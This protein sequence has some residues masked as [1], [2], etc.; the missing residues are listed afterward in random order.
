MVVHAG[1]APTATR[2]R[3]SSTAWRSSASDLVKLG[4]T[5]DISK[6][7]LKHRVGAMYISTAVIAGDYLYTYNDVGVPGCYE[8]KTGKEL[9][10]DQIEERPG[11]TTAWGSPV[12][13]A[14][15][16]YITD[17][18]GTTSVFAAGPKYELLATNRLQRT[19]QRLDRRRRTATSS[20][21]RTSTCGASARRSSAQ[22]QTSTVG[23]I[24][25]PSLSA[26]DG[27]TIHPTRSRHV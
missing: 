8:W 9:W 13:A 21:A 1:R 19:L 15:R 14:G 27:S 24:V 16:I 18:Q 17:Q 11:G 3:C 25:N 12:H 2:R 10:K 20:S 7:R 6:D 5:G 23:R 4:G 26:L 22:T